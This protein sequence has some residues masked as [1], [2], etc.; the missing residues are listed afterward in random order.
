MRLLL[1]TLFLLVAAPAAFAESV[2]LKACANPNMPAA[3]TIRFCQE[4][5]QDRGLDTSTRARVLTNLGVGLAEQGRHSEAIL[6]FGLA[7]SADPGLT[8]AY[9]YRARSNEALGR[10]QDAYADFATALEVAPEDASIWAA[11]GAMLLRQNRIAEAEGNLSRAIELD[12]RN[13][14]ARYNRG[15]ALLSLGDPVAAEADFDSVLEISDNDAAA[16][17]NRGQAR[18]LQGE[19]S[20]L[21]DFDRAV[22]LAPDW[23]AAYYARGRYLDGA[24]DKERADTDFLRAFELGVSNPFL[25]ERVRQIS[26]N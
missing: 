9:T 4:A 2:V 22:D 8:V 11:Q 17:L 16:L 24:G 19:E 13:L 25:I 7:T 15:L 14:S 5:L 20:A 1:L 26:G 23:G 12:P 6:N 10:L 3:D 21:A 18:A